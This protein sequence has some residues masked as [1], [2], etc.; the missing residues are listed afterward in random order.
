M[1]VGLLTSIRLSLALVTLVIAPTVTA[2]NFPPAL[3]PRGLISDGQPVSDE[4][5][6]RPLIGKLASNRINGLLNPSNLW[7]REQ[8]PICAVNYS[9]CAGT[10]FCCPDGG[11]C[12]PGELSRLLVNKSGGGSAVDDSYDPFTH[13]WPILVGTCCNAGYGFH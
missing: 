13:R 4:A 2:A 5:L 11:V 7:P 1:T 3:D 12:C 6:L 8:A 9:T 10:E